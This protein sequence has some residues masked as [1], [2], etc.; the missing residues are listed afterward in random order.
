M[1]DIDPKVI[2]FFSECYLCENIKDEAAILKLLEN[3]KIKKYEP[4]NKIISI[5]DFPSSVYY[6]INGTVKVVVHNDE[7]REII[8]AQLSSGDLFGEFSALD[9]TLTSANI[10]TLEICEFIAIP[11][12]DFSTVINNNIDFLRNIN[13]RLLKIIRN[14]G[15]HIEILSY[16]DNKLRV[17]EVLNNFKRIEGT[18]SI[19]RPTAINIAAMCGL[20]RETVSKTL[21]ELNKKKLIKLDV[22]KITIL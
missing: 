6:I 21:N 2:E 13:T 22:D 7:N 16:K 17:M 4:N 12:K 15:K 5:E 18:N 9:D 3:A 14:S 10:I 11:A 19:K 20:A 8:L 1:N